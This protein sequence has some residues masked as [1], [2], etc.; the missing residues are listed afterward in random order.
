MVAVFVGAHTHTHTHTMVQLILW[1]KPVDCLDVGR[2][3]AN[4]DRKWTRA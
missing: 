4:I 3:R 2:R 1:E